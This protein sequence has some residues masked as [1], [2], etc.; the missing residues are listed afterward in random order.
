MI[1]IVTVYAVEVDEI[2]TEIIEVSDI[3]EIADNL[4]K[5]INHYKNYWRSRIELVSVVK[6]G[7]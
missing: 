3:E 6:G 1:Y 4:F 7:R 2:E 5:I